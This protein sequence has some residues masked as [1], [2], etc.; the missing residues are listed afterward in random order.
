MN[1]A[2][3]SHWLLLTR[4]KWQQK[5]LKK[6]FW[7]AWMTACDSMSHPLHPL[8]P[9]NNSVII[10]PSHQTFSSLHPF[11]M[12]SLVLFSSLYIWTAFL[13]LNFLSNI[14]E[15]LVLFKIFMVHFF[16]QK[17]PRVRISFNIF[18]FQP[19]PWP[20]LPNCTLPNAVTL[21]SL[22]LN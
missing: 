6:A 18:M 7:H 3:S 5:Q 4:R 14:F 2:L 1:S 20:S 11:D 13:L 15:L 10:R 21:A 9:L 16:L 17:Y 12:P 19:L 22:A 8:P